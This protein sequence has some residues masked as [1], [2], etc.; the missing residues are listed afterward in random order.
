VLSA[1]LL[2]IEPQIYNCVSKA[3]IDLLELTKYCAVSPGKMKAND[4]KRSLAL[5]AFVMC[6]LVCS[7]R[8]RPA[9][10]QSQVHVDAQVDRA[11]SRWRSNDYPGIRYVGSNAC[12]GCHKGKVTTQSA[13]AMAHALEPA[14]DCQALSAH[15]KLT[16]QNGPYSYEIVREGNRS[17]Y[18]V[19]D[20]ARTVSEPILYC[21]GQGVAGQTYVFRHNGVFYESRISYYQ[22]SQNFDITMLHSRSIPATLE[23]A[24]GRPMSAEAAEGCFSCHSTPAAGGPLLQADHLVPG[25][26]CERCHGPGEKHIAA[27]KAGNKDLQIFN[28]GKL[29]AIDLTQEFCGNCHQSFE[30]VMQMP[31]QGGANNIRFQ[32]YRMFNSRGHLENDPRISCV[33][34]HDPHDKM[35]REPAFYDSKCLACHLSNGKEAGTVK[36]AAAPCPVS[37]QQCVTCHMP[38]V[39]LAEMHFKFTDHWIRIVKP[40]GPVPR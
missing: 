40:G 4:I 7:W 23:E 30:T 20:G 16:F 12:A 33:V 11:L 24:L 9:L 32:P 1:A 25:V 34:C 17:L 3:E 36:R 28:P 26:T 8:P 13:T 5:G 2:F 14:A 35:Q 19:T 37:S 6:A 27:V 10:G 39:E 29:D 22:E 15:Q 31:S 38:K 18:T 21:F